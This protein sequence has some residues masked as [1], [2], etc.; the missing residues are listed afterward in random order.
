MHTAAVAS[1]ACCDR[2]WFK[3]TELPATR[4]DC[5]DRSKIT[6][7]LIG[8]EGLHVQL[9]QAHEGTTEIRLLHP[10]PID[11]HADRYN[12][13]AMLADNVDCFLDASAARDDGDANIRSSRENARDRNASLHP[14]EL[15]SKAGMCPS[16]LLGV[17]DGGG[18]P[19]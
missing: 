3:T 8:R 12:C 10:T 6:W 4:F 14:G 7:N 16:T 15:R 13:A 1:F 2:S 18:L 5:G 9:H 17:G 11:D 19:L